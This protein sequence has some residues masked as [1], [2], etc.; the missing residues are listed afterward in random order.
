MSFLTGFLKFF[1]GLFTR[2]PLISDNKVLIPTPS[3]IEEKDLKVSS[4]TPLTQVD[5]VSTFEKALE[6]VLRWE[7]GYVN[8]PND[9]GGATNKGIIQKEYDAY[10][11][12]KKLSNRSVKEIEDTEVR[13]IYENK[14]WKMGH[15]DVMNDKLSLVHFDTI[16]NVGITQGAKFL[17]RCLKVKDDGK[18][19]N[20]TLKALNASNQD[21]LIPIYL[22]QRKSFYQ[23]IVNVNPKL[24]I[25]LKGW[26][27]RV[28]S[29]EKAVSC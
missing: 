12:E 13:D 28:N 19:G 8:N 22:N 7:A 9:P 3:K 5:I 14:Y 25:F 11:T 6:F 17:Q 2:E 26:I 10:R 16:V 23:K 27:N 4:L 21:S 15:C 1:T 24:Q 29:V 18:I 20:G